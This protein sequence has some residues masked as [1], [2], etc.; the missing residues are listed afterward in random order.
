MAGGSAEGGLSAGM[1]PAQ[2]ADGQDQKEAG[3]HKQ[4]AAVEPVDRIILQAGSGEQAVK[5][6]RG[7]GEIDAEMEGFPK[8]AAQAKAEKGSNDN[9]GQEVERDG[10]NRVFQR[11]AGRVDGVGQVQKTKARIPVDEQD[12]WMQERQRESHVAGPI[13]EAE[14]VE[15]VMRPAAM[16]AVA[17]GHEHSE[18]QVQHDRA[19]GHQADVGREVEDG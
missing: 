13:V 10:T 11:L 7:G 17:K 5:E 9:E 12:R 19:N 15:A 2:Q 6:Q 1:A 16:G 3:F 8:V 14:V 4:F 18:E